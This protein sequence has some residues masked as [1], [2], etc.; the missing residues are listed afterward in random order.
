MAKP[1]RKDMS[2]INNNQEQILEKFRKQEVREKRFKQKLIKSRK[3]FSNHIFKVRQAEYFQDKQTDRYRP[4]KVLLKEIRMAMRSKEAAGLLQKTLKSYEGEE[5]QVIEEVNMIK[6]RV[7]QDEEP[8]TSDIIIET[9]T[10]MLHEDQANNIDH[11][12]KASRMQMLLKSSAKA[13]HNSVTQSMEDITE[14]GLQ[15]LMEG[16]IKKTKQTFDKA[17][18]DEKIEETQIRKN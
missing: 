18:S 11:K 10:K 15:F 14:V 5:K 7:N 13:F 4:S 12:S 3:S 2:A 9:V 6:D 16:V 1:E 17:K 8:L